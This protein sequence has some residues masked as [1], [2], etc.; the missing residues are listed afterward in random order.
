[1]DLSDF[2]TQLSLTATA[3]T[4]DLKTIRTGRANPVIVEQ[5]VVDAYG[6]STKL[7]LMELSTITTEGPRGVG[8]LSF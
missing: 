2:K 7:K 4:E 1:M 6:G 5:L 3:L 8:Y